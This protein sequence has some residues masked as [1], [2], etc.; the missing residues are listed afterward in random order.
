MTSVP[1]QYGVGYVPF[2]YDPNIIYFDAF[3]GYPTIPIKAIV[4]YPSAPSP[5]TVIGYFSDSSEITTQFNVTSGAIRNDQ[6]P[7]LVTFFPDVSFGIN[8]LFN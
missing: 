6:Q 3:S 7:D 8:F 4:I 2:D 5:V 1:F